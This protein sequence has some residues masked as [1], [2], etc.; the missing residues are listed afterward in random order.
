MCTTGQQQSPIDV[1]TK[2]A[3]P[4]GEDA[5]E[6]DLVFGGYGGKVE[7]AV[8]INN[9]HTAKVTPKFA[10]GQTP[11]TVGTAVHHVGKSCN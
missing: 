4:A 8:L 7:S 10:E 5:A 9:G 1:D 2:K 3:A 6:G 11:P